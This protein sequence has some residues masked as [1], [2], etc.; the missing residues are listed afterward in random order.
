MMTLSETLLAG[1]GVA[2]S[3]LRSSEK[4]DAELSAIAAKAQNAW[5][6]LT[7]GLHEFVAKLSESLDTADSIEALQGLHHEDLFL[8]AVCATGD[9]DGLNLFRE[10]YENDIRNIL[11]RLQLPAHDID[12][13]MQQL[14][15]ILFVAKPG[16][17]AKIAE[18]RGRGSLLGYVRV[19]ATRIGVLIKRASQK[20][21]WHASQE[22]LVIA[23]D[24]DD[25]A[26]TYQKKHYRSQFKRA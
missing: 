2:S 20:T 21:P 16:S 23:N 3:T 9:I 10:R 12:D 4:L 24:D 26:L 7:L 6:S 8:A 17:V 15:G 13:A 11:G 22:L 1:L 25:Q 19:V 18:Y 14:S 5:P